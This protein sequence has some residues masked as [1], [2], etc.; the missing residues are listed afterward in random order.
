[1]GYSSIRAS[2]REFWAVLVIT[3]FFMFASTVAVAQCTPAF[4]GKGALKQSN[5]IFVE[6]SLAQDRT[7]LTGSAWYEGRRHKIERGSVQGT[8]ETTGSRGILHLQIKW[9]YGETGVYDGT[10]TISDGDDLVGTAF[11]KEDPL[12]EKRST[13]W[14]WWWHVNCY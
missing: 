11:I 10:W 5:G 13:R 1:M 3:L 4:R 9:D 12:N 6:M 7:R 14:R 2:V 8:A